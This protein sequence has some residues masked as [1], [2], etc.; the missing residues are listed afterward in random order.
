[1]KTLISNGTNMFLLQEEHMEPFRKKMEEFLRKAES[2]L[3]ELS[4]L[5][6]QLLP[7]SVGTFFPQHNIYVMLM[8]QV[9]E[10]CRKFRLSVRFYQFAKGEDDPKEFFSVWHPFCRDFKDLWKREQVRKERGEI[11]LIHAYANPPRVSGPTG[12]GVAPRGEAASQEEE[13]EHAGLPDRG[14]QAKG[15]QGEDDEEKVQDAA[16]AAAVAAY[17]Y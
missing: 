11:D 14:A 9:E 13:G 10:S 4:E 6:I 16:A 1:M 3:G 15:A 17:T 7:Y 2:N 8:T 5:V 12:E